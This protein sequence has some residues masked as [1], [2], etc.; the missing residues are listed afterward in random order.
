MMIPNIW[1]NK[2]HVPNQ[3]PVMAASNSAEKM[4][5]HGHPGAPLYLNGPLDFSGP[6]MCDPPPK[7]GFQTMNRLYRNRGH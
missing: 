7:T 1:E 3:Q 6:N 5:Q 2:S 4:F